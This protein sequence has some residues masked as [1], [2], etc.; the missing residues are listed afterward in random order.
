MRKLFIHQPLF[1]IFCPVFSGVI[2]YLLILLIN[3][4]VAQI[5]E[6]FLGDELYV[7]I[8]LSYLTQEGV[9]LLLSLLRGKK[10]KPNAS[11]E[12]GLQV[13]LSVLLCVII[14][15]TSMALFYKYVE[16]YTIN[17][18]ELLVFN[19]IFVVISFIY[20]LLFVSHQYLYNINSEKLNYEELIRQNIEDEF[21][22]FKRDINPRLLFDSLES[23]LSFIEDDLDDSDEFI[24]HLSVLYRYIL[25]K[26]EKQLVAFE[27]EL[28]TAQELIMLLGKLPLRNLHLE[29]NVNN[30]FLLVP[31]TLLTL[32]ELISRTSIISDKP[33]H[34]Q[35][36]ENAEYFYLQ[37]RSNDRITNVIT[38]KDIKGVQEVYS[39]YSE[40]SVEISEDQDT[41]KIQI[42]KLML[43]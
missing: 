28:T 31:G 8:G 3:N 4:N 13:G 5:Q 37:Y 43:A 24:D 30:E 27:D 11:V 19:S 39:I 21:L 1:R 18:D 12:I 34:V 35:L 41:R 29:S 2:V 17:L 38:K 10:L 15:S 22:Q 33:L 26:K 23:L 36:Y 40:K 16:K 6:Q 25:S 20:V 9:R 42:P 7:F 14:V 32:L